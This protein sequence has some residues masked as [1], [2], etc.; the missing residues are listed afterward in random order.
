MNPKTRSRDTAGPSEAQR[1]DAVRSLHYALRIVRNWVDAGLPIP[2]ND[3][4]AL[5]DA[6]TRYT[7]LHTEEDPDV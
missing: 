3:V 2:A 6:L 1:G 4:A 7:D 5:G